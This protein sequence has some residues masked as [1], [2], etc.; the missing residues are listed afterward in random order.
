M[1]SVRFN[2]SDCDMLDCSDR[3]GDGKSPY[4]PNWCPKEVAQRII[5]KAVKEI[6][7]EGHISATEL[8]KWLNKQ[9]AT[10]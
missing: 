10:E 8:K 7:D 1:S 2:C 5:I 4:S 3:G 6:V 9:G